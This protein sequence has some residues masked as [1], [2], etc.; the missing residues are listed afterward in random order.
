ML[1][2][3]E[4]YFLFD[5]PYSFLLRVCVLGSI[6][7]LQR[8]L[9]VVYFYCSVIFTSFIN[10]VY[11]LSCQWRTIEIMLPQLYYL[12]ILLRFHLYKYYGR[13]FNKTTSQS[14]SNRRLRALCIHGN[15]TYLVYFCQDSGSY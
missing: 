13:K 5:L 11:L 12:W 10:K 4:Y 9:T 6:F 15:G 7:K 2:F 3:D 1:L 8:F 14:T